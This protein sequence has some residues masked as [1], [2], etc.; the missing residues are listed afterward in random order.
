MSTVRQPPN[1]NPGA[2]R[3]GGKFLNIDRRTSPENR[4]DDEGT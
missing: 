2:S 3:Q 1:R 4:A